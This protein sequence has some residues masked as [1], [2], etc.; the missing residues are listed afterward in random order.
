VTLLLLV[1]VMGRSFTRTTYYNAFL[2]DVLFWPLA[3]V[4]LIAIFLAPVTSGSIMQLDNRLWERW[5]FVCCC[6]AFAL[7][8][9]WWSTIVAQWMIDQ[10]T[11]LDVGPLADIGVVTAK[12]S[13]GG[14]TPNTNPRSR[15]EHYKW[16]KRSRA[17]YKS[18]CKNA[19]WYKLVVHR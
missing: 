7:A 18:V 1:F 15:V 6:L 16:V 8:E 3:T 13:I 10:V 14:R 17:R 4:W 11:A 19:D 5:L 2:L 9:L 12:E